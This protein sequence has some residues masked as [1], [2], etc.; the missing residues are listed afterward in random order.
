MCKHTH[1]SCFVSI[2]VYTFHSHVAADTD[3]YL[4]IFKGSMTD[5]HIP[6]S[7]R[8]PAYKLRLPPKRIFFHALSVDFVEERR[9]SLDTYLRSLLGDPN[10]CRV[11]FLFCTNFFQF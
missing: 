5:F 6:T 10:L 4:R 3:E 9:D 11:F 2:S 7:N 8:Y 1:I